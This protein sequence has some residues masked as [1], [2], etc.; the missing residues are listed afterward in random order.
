MVVKSLETYLEEVGAVQLCAVRGKA[1]LVPY[2]VPYKYGNLV[3]LTREQA[4]LPLLVNAR[5][6][7]KHSRVAGIATVQAQTFSRTYLKNP[8]AILSMFDTES[9][10]FPVPPL[11]GANKESAMADNGEG[12]PLLVGEPVRL[13]EQPSRRVKLITQTGEGVTLSLSGG[14]VMG[15]AEHLNDVTGELSLRA[16]QTCMCCFGLWSRDRLSM[17]EKAYADG[18]E[19]AVFAAVA[20]VKTDEER[21]SLLLHHFDRMQKKAAKAALKF[22]TTVD[23]PYA[24]KLY[25]KGMGVPFNST[26]CDY[27]YACGELAPL[28]NADILDVCVAAGLLPRGTKLPN[29]QGIAA[30]DLDDLYRQ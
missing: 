1:F 24:P 5:E 8:G 3:R 21:V 11:G 16:I 14:I 25:T 19:P 12:E 27:L 15:D 6:R 7:L 26:Q 10:T 30:D 13:V 22:Y 29:P 20:E 28:Q 23:D 9:K 17:V 4:S 18:G 2:V